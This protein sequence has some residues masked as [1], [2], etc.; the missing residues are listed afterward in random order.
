[1]NSILGHAT[2]IAFSRFNDSSDFS[3]NRFRSI[4]RASDWV[5]IRKNES[6]SKKEIG[7]Q[8]ELLLLLLLF[9]YAK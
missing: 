9:L 2:F 3:K 7:I 4:V 1:M 6:T 5:G 8:N